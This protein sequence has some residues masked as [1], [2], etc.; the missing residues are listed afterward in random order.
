MTTSD[1]GMGNQD[2]AGWRTT[3]SS[4]SFEERVAALE[5]VVER[6]EAGNVSIDEAIAL[7]ELGI[8]LASSASATIDAAELRVEE[9]SRVPDT[10]GRQPRVIKFPPTDDD[11]GDEGASDEAPF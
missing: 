3:L 2:I 5:T 9:L 1:T 7:Y 11:G 8:G 10:N 6:L 4:G